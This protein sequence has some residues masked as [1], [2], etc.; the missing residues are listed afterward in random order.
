MQQF[1]A[2]PYSL[3][4]Q[5]LGTDSCSGALQQLT[6]DPYS[7]RQRLVTGSSYTYG[8]AQRLGLAPRQFVDRLHSVSSLET[9]PHI[10]DGL[11]RIVSTPSFLLRTGRG[12]VV[13]VH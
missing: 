1:T 4:Q 5:L 10:G 7:L 12:N 11:Q 13:F 6:A 3:Q 2:D 8:G 9:R